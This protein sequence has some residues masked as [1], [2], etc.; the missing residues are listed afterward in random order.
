M[1]LKIHSHLCCVQV[2]CSC[3][4]TGAG[5]ES[6]DCEAAEAE[7]MHCST[8]TETADGPGDPAIYVQRST[9]DCFAKHCEVNDCCNQN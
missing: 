2:T 3:H 4:V 6:S 7:A 8:N 1:L 9:A 5:A